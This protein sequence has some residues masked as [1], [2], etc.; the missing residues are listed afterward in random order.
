MKTN[1]SRCPMGQSLQTIETLITKETDDCIPWPYAVGKAGYGMTWANGKLTSAH[2]AAWYLAH[3]KPIPRKRQGVRSRYLC[4]LHSCD[5]RACIN[6]RH[7]FRGTQ[8]ISM[9]SMV[10]K[11]R[12]VN[13]KGTHWKCLTEDQIKN[14]HEMRGRGGSVVEIAS[15]LSISYWA[16]WR[17]IN[18]KPG[19]WK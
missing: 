19:K 3:R 12:A 5:N 13:R 14:I 18:N 4:V 10:A 17:R 8:A 16:V 15:K 9:A 11:G 1:R 7:L 6:P 2:V